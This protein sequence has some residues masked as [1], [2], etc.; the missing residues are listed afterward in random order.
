M[1]GYWMEGSVAV[2]VVG[3][4]GGGVDQCVVGMEG[5]VAVATFGSVIGGLGTDMIVSI[6]ECW[7]RSF[8]KLSFV[9]GGDGEEEGGGRE[10]LVR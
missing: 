4:G 8:T 6:R 5:E 10:L 9:E 2:V 1:L 7:T 3:C